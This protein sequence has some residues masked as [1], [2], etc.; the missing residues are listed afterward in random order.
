MI[1]AFVISTSVLAAG[2]KKSGHFEIK[3]LSDE[4]ELQK[5]SMQNIPETIPGYGIALSSREFEV[6]IEAADAK[7]IHEGQKAIVNSIPAREHIFCQVSRV[8]RNVS[9]ETGQAIAWLRPNKSSSIINGE[10]IFASITTN[11]LHHALSV[12]NEAILIKEGKT[13]VIKE[14]KSTEKGKE[15]KSVYVPTPI[16]LGFQ[17][18]EIAEVKSGLSPNDQIVTQAGIGFLFPDFKSGAD[19]D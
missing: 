19:G 13:M 3:E 16:V 15:G 18:P 2:C 6:S 5:V 12:P 9:S 4:P 17:S 11:V 8:S 14:T 7:L 10:F 1:F